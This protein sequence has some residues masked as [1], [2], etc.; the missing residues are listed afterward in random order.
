MVFKK[1]KL[2]ASFIART[3]HGEEK[4]WSQKTSQKE[5]SL[6]KSFIHLC[7]FE[8]VEHIENVYQSHCYELITFL[9]LQCNLMFNLINSLL[10]IIMNHCRMGCC[11]FYLFIDCLTK[12]LI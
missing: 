3:L 6:S 1:E 7:I 11:I 5:F 9:G 2:I 10:F 4:T 8:H 12:E